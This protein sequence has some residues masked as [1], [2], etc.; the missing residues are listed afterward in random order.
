LRVQG[1]GDNEGLPNG[2][3]SYYGLKG[4][5]AK[6]N[7]SSPI[8]RGDLR[9]M[10]PSKI[11]HKIFDLIH[12]IKGYISLSKVDEIAD[13]GATIRSVDEINVYKTDMK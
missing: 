9:S 12:N 13:H 7:A 11:L 6:V 3:R 4:G 8:S 2:R 1:S 5:N 10:D